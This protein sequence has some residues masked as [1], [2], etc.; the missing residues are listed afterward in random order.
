MLLLIY[1]DVGTLIADSC[2]LRVFSCKSFFMLPYLKFSFIGWVGF[3]MSDINS[4]IINLLVDFFPPNYW[5]LYSCTF[6]DLCW[7]IDGSIP[8]IKLSTYRRRLNSESKVGISLVVFQSSY[9]SS[10]HH[11]CGYFYVRWT[12]CLYLI[13]I[14]WLRQVSQD[15]TG[16]HKATSL[17]RNMGSQFSCMIK[18]ARVLGTALG[19]PCIVG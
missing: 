5:W 11:L 3:W 14:F 4:D 1:Q 17:Q 15:E 9:C 16:S 19:I 6:G 18:E 10:L 2:F 8:S 7:P 13:Y 12:V